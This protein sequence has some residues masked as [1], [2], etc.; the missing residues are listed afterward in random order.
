MK[1]TLVITLALIS[2]AQATPT[3]PKGKEINTSKQGHSDKKTKVSPSSQKF[4]VSKMVEVSGKKIKLTLTVDLKGH[5]DLKPRV[6]EM[7]QLYFAQW[8]KIVKMLNAPIDRTP[9]HLSLSFRENLG[10]PAHV[11]GTNIVIEGKHL[12]LHPDDTSGVFVHELTH[13][14]QSYPGGAPGWFAEGTADYV[15]Y[16]TFPNSKW[17]NRN[18]ARTDKTKPLSAYWNSTAFLLWIEKT[19]K[20]NTVS[21]VSRLCKEGKYNEDVWK[22]FTGKSLKELVKEYKT[23]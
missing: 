20:P 9:T 3:T 15:R 2:F 19:Q 5:R 17:A 11:A 13:F 23:S 7:T 4:S 14:V 16:K 12:R 22:K 18:K 21:Q 1:F 6:N 8:P 10:H